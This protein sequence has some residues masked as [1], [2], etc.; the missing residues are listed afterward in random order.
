[1]ESGDRQAAEHPHVPNCYPLLGQ[2]CKKSGEHHRRGEHEIGTLLMILN[3]VLVQRT[4]SANSQFYRIC[5]NRTRGEKW[6]PGD[7][8]VRFSLIKHPEQ[9][10][11]FKEV[12]AP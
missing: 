1:M 9:S 6:Q 12:F 4:W 5:I 2:D 7:G 8:A 11:P 3:G 10:N